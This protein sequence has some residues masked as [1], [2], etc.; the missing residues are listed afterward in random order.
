MGDTSRANQAWLKRALGIFAYYAK[1][2]QD[3]STK[4]RPLASAKKFPLDKEALQAFSLLKL[5]LERTTLYSVDENLPFE[6][7][8]DASEVAISAVL[9]QGGRPVALM[10]KALQGSE[11]RYH[12]VEKEV[13]A[14]IEAV[15]KWSHFLSRQQFDLITDQRSVPFMFD[16]QKHTDQEYQDPGVKDGTH[17][18]QLYRTLSPWNIIRVYGSQNLPHTKRSCYE[19]NYPISPYRQWTSGTAQRYYMEGNPAGPE[20]AGPTR[21][22]LGI[23]ELLDVN[24]TYANIRHQDGR[25]STVSVRDLA[26][27]PKRLVNYSPAGNQE[28]SS[29]SSPEVVHTAIFP[30][31]PENT[32]LHQEAD[33][34]TNASTPLVWR[35]THVSKALD[36][37]GWD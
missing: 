16:N 2:I 26:P 29:T 6:V 14:I 23:I 13:M 3:F 37:Y 27:Y 28:S 30:D 1:W 21:S 9:N 33:V 4:V 17:C 19:S 25:E 22:T 34:E 35:S 32:E 5:E 36:R 10:S 8:C 20:V 24:P 7:E 15:R 18:L 12:I 11:T 31:I